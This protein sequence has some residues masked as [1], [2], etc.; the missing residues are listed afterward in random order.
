M[1][2]V[3]S[4]LVD[5]K[6]R[7][8]TGSDTFTVKNPASGETFPDIFPISNWTDIEAALAAAE[9]AF[10]T[11]VNWPGS[12]FAELLEKYADRLDAH[13][14]EICLLAHQETAFPVP[15]RLAGNE[16]PRTTNQ[17]RL[18]AKS[19]REG[20]WRMATIDTKANIRSM[21]VSLGP[22]VVM[23]P[24]NFPLAY[25]AISG[26]D[27]ASAIATG[28]P[29]IAKAHPLHPR[30][31]MRMAELAHEVAT[32]LGFPGGFIQQI[33]HLPNELGL[34]MLSD[35]RIKAA[36]FTGSR[37]AGLKIKE[38]CDTNGKPVYLEMSSVNPVYLLPGA[39]SER[40][41]ELV[42][43]FSGSCLLGSGQFCTNPGVVILFENADTQPFIEGVVEKFKASAPVPMLSGEGR[44]G[45][46]KS[47]QYLISEGAELLCGGKVVDGSHSMHEP[48][49]L[50]VTGKQFL[51]KPHEFQSE[52]FGAS[53]LFVVVKDAAELLAI[54]AHIHGSLTASV[55]SA[56][57]GADDEVYEQL[58]GLLTRTAGRFLNDKM[59]TGVAVSPAMNHGGPFPATGHPHFTAVGIPG[60]LRRFGMLVSYD[61]V[62]PERLPT[63]LKD[64]NPGGVW[65]YVD[66][67]WTTDDATSA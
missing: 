46:H 44:D 65:R 31:S 52:A 62:R 49:L 22:V 30:T 54:T 64:K 23:G 14:D 1:P 57:S 8:S 67:V 51:A 66:Y 38:A 59:P 29:V 27:F 36:A 25:N 48:T 47:L 18:A 56:K 20:S 7:P 5:G 35:R 37:N 41:G 3:H 43:E 13:K 53:S 61:N 28:N 45:F 32:E 21:L 34:K 26:G 10:H 6:F 42:D 17:L 16:F 9:K 55:Y 24:N 60:S 33:Y 11:V 4:I 40:R 63:E 58:S 19:A 50:K 39:L 12:K 2:Q 15:T